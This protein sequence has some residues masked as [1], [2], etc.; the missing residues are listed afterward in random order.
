MSKKWQIIAA[1]AVMLLASVASAAPAAEATS[2]REPPATHHYVYYPAH[3]LYFSTD[4]QMWFWPDGDGWASGGA[5]PIPLQQYAQ[6]GYNVY[7]DA[8]RPYDA[9]QDVDAGYRRHK[10]TPYRYGDDAADGVRTAAPRREH[11]AG[12]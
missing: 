11:G 7:L 9:Q 1:V 6:D 10:W 12:K 5:L 2:S 4:T 3:H 8:D